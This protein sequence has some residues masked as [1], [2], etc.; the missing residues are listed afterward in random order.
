MAATPFEYRFRFALHGIIYALGFWAP[1]T[2]YTSALGPRET[3][4]NTGMSELARTGAFSF[5]C[6][7]IFLLS[8][9]ILLAAVGAWLRV[10]GSAYVGASIVNSRSM[11]GEAM[12]ADGPYRRTRNPLYLG[13]LLHTFGVALVMPLSGAVFAIVLLWIFQIRLALAE[14]PF[15]SARFGEPYCL[16]AARVPRFL[17][18]LTPRVP[19]AGAHPRWLQACLGEIYMIGVVVSFAAL[20]WSFNSLTLIKGIVV[21]LGLSFIVRAFIPRP[22]VTSPA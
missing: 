4:W 12:L 13:T 5:N 21:S 15:L 20:G 7:A 18:A 11:H 8:L 17:P 9:G 10:W 1:W 22:Q 6:A 2:L 14:E 16:Y 19:S 3:L